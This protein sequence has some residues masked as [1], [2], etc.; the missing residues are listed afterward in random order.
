MALKTLRLGRC[1]PFHVCVGQARWMTRGTK[2]VGAMGKREGD[3]SDA[4]T[5]LSGKMAEPLPHRFRLLKQELAKGNEFPIIN[6]WTRLLES[7]KKENETIAK[8]GPRVIPEVRY[9][10]LEED[11]AKYAHIIKKRGVVVIRGVIPE[12][13]ARAYK[14]EI[15][16]YVKLNPQTKGKSLIGPSIELFSHR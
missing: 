12:D 2:T 5:S 3:I 8:R 16:D 4:F 10:H 11:L 6:G 15:E 13:E 14:S 1:F 9:S 7:L